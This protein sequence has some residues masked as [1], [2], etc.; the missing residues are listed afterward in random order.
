VVLDD[1]WHVVYDPSYMPSSSAL[2]CEW[3]YSR[4]FIVSEIY[5]AR[6]N[7]VGPVQK[8]LH[9]HEIK[10]LPDVDKVYVFVDHY[11]LFETK[12]YRSFVSMNVNR[13]RSLQ[14]L[15]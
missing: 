2:S 12:E 5:D 7:R 15:K 4:R 8:I 14:R 3:E 9:K 1:D 6:V 11:G 13:K 10:G